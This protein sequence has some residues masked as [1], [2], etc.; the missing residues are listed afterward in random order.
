M[1]LQHSRLLCESIKSDCTLHVSVPMS[2]HLSRTGHPGC[3]CSILGNTDSEPCRCCRSRWSAPD[4]TGSSGP[5]TG[6]PL[7][8]HVHRLAP[9]FNYASLLC[10]KLT[11]NATHLF[12]ETLGKTSDILALI[13]T[14]VAT[15]QRSIVGVMLGSLLLSCG[16]TSCFYTQFFFAK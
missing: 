13:T 15:L 6:S 11:T 3:V 10:F 1:D 2:T 16:L 5:R 8:R 9:L 12:Y 4:Y 14:R 7:E